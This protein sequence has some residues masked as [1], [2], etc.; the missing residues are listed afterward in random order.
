MSEENKIKT[1][2]K[3]N[4]TFYYQSTIIYF[5]AFIL[6]A[7][8]RGEFVEDSFKLLLKD[9]IIYFFAIIVLVS[10]IG[11]LFNLYKNR[12]L[13]IEGEKI[14]FKDRFGVRLFTTDQIERIKISKQKGM[15]KNKAFRLIRIKLKHR[16]RSIII[17]P[18]DYENEEELTAKFIELKERLEKI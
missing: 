12:Y 11:L 10:L 4:L 2:F 1:S 17:R 16:R 3:Y 6:Y 14:S 9:P 8:I 15:M 5:V 13:I 18:N 7:L